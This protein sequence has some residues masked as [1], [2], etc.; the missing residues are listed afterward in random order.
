MTSSALD[1]QVAWVRQAAG[2]RFAALEL[3]MLAFATI[4][5]PDRQAAAE[6]VAQQFQVPVDLA[7]ATPYLLLGTEEQIVAQLQANRA[8]FGVSYVAIFEDSMD[9]F[10]PVVA[11]LAGQ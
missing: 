11:R 5:T 10:A 1:E 7:L 9:A 8:R 6:Q 4:V 2:D 3:N